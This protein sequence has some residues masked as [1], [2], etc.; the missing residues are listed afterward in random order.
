MQEIGIY[1]PQRRE[2]VVTVHQKGGLPDVRDTLLG[3]SC[4]RCLDFRSQIQLDEQLQRF[5]QL[6]YQGEMAIYV[7][8]ANLIDDET[9][10]TDLARKYLHQDADQRRF[11]WLYRENPFG[12]AR[13]WIAYE[14]DTEA[15]GMAAVFPRQMYCAGAVVLSCVLGDLCIATKYRSLGPALQLQRA[16][17]EC[18]RSGEFGIAYD[19]PGTTMLG[20]YRHLGIQPVATSIRMAKVLRADEKVRRV[21]PARILS[22]PAAAAAN[23]ALSVADR[24]FA[25]VPGIEFEL[26]EAPCTSE[27]SELASRIGSSLGACTIRSAEYLN[28]RYRQHPHRKYEFF[29]ARQNSGMLAYCTF[30]VEDGNAIVAELFGSIDHQALRNLLQRLVVLLRARG[31]A[32]L[33]LPMLNGDRRADELRRM[34]FRAREAVPVMVFGPKA[35]VAGTPM[36]LMHGDRE[37]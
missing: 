29:V 7:R 18:V 20:I 25:D 6:L 31:V 34:G 36:L 8:L 19:F 30:A 14:N 33:S 12:P 27:Y 28:W 23:F 15:V 1:F 16:C 5:G 37:S 9:I 3:Y 11:Q 2:K 24:T 4:R 22:R 26:E 10:L 17:L 35:E 21:I 13:A 32:T